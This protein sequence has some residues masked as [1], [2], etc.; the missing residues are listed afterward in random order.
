MEADKAVASAAAEI[1]V[2]VGPGNGEA[3]SQFEIRTSLQAAD[4]LATVVAK[5]LEEGGKPAAI[6][7]AKTVPAWQ[8][9]SRLRSYGSMSYAGFKSLIYAKL[10]RNDERVLAAYKA[11][12]RGD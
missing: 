10:P 9:V 7:N 8:G 12:K 5:A 2:L 3:S 4:A 1:I 6:V 11:V